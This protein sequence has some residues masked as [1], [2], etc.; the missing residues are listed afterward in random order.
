MMDHLFSVATTMKFMVLYFT[1]GYIW[2]LF[3]LLRHL[4]ITYPIIRDINSIKKPQKHL[5]TI[6]LLQ[7][8]SIT[9]PN[10]NRRL[11]CR[12]IFQH[13]LLNWKSPFYLSFL[14]NLIF[15]PIVSFSSYF[16][17]ITCQNVKFLGFDSVAATKRLFLMIN[18]QNLIDWPIDRH[19]DLTCICFL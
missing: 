2:R 8:I 11:N 12:E 6:I 3:N 5:S 10:A 18:G 17:A 15:F 14:F 9:V 19:Q 4:L 16:S 1:H 13:K 7:F